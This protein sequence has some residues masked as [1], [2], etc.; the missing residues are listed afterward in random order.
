MEAS[1]E[2]SGQKK[3]ALCRSGNWTSDSHLP[4]FS[5][6]HVQAA[7]CEDEMV[8]VEVGEGVC[9]EGGRRMDCGLRVEGIERRMGERG[10]WTSSKRS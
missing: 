7:S 10:T 2:T 3:G 6:I 5:L 8:L 1:S 4:R 9:K